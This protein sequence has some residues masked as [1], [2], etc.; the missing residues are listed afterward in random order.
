MGGVAVGDGVAER[1]LNI[2][3][4]TGTPI[5]TA[6]D[7]CEVFNAGRDGCVDIKISSPLVSSSVVYPEALVDSNRRG[8]N[9]GVACTTLI[10]TGS[11]CSGRGEPIWLLDASLPSSLSSLASSLEN[12][13]H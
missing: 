2:D 13:S 11:L 7:W 8:L 5:L 9:V 10:D 12:I 6:Y 4:C 3:C 1:R